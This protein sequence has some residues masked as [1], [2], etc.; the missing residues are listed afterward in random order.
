MTIAS[1]LLAISAV[2]A[3]GADQAVWDQCNRTRDADASIVACTQ[4]LK[5]PDETNSNRAITYYV[6]A[7]VYR[8]KGDNDQAIADYT[9]AIEINPQHVA[10]YNSRSKAFEARGE[11]DRAIADH[12]KAIEINQP[13][14]SE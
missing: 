7:G 11:I 6:R 9:K 2:A 3:S 5:A 10:A 12:K 4:I 14:R 13:Y 8:I 1:L